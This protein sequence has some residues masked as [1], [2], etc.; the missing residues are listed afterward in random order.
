MKGQVKLKKYTLSSQQNQLL[1]YYEYVA[2]IP[3]ISVNGC[4]SFC[5]VFL[6]SYAALTGNKLMEPPQPSR[7]GEIRCLILLVCTRK[8]IKRPQLQQVLTVSQ[9]VMADKSNKPGHSLARH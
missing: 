7:A 2:R 5:A 4:R 1:P 9:D 8:S 6:W 3:L